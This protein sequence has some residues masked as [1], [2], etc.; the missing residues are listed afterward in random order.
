MLWH[1]MVYYSRIQFLA[2]GAFP[3]RHNTGM[4]GSVGARKL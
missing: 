4:D 1:F 2:V 3:Q